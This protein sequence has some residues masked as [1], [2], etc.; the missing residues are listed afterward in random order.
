MGAIPMGRG[1]GRHV[2]LMAFLA[3][4]AFVLWSYLP[5]LMPLIDKSL[6]FCFADFS[7]YVGTGSAA[8]RAE[9]TFNTFDHGRQV[10]ETNRAF[11]IESISIPM[12]WIGASDSQTTSLLILLSIILGCIGLG[13]LIGMIDGARTGWTGAAIRLA[14]IPL[15]FLNL[16]SVERTIHIWIWMTYAILPLL[17]YLGLSYLDKKGRVEGLVAYSLLF[18]VYGMVPHSL[19]YAAIIHAFLAAFALAMLIRTK[20]LDAKKVALFMALPCAVFVLTNLPVLLLPA[21][22]SLSYP[23]TIDMGMLSML[24]RNGYLIRALTM[25]NNWWPQVD[26]GLTP[27]NALCRAS[28]L[29]II[30]ATVLFSALMM[31]KLDE[32]ARWLA[33]LSIA[34]ILCSLLIAQG[35]NDPIIRAASSSLQSYGLLWA[36]ALFREWARICVMIPVFMATVFALAASAA[37]GRTRAIAVLAMLSLVIMNIASSPA[38]EQLRRF[39]AVQVP[40]DYYNLSALPSSDKILMIWPSASTK[41]NGN[42]AYAWNEEKGRGNNLDWFHDGYGSGLEAVIAKEDAPKG[43]LD[44]LD[45]R[46]V[47]STREELGAQGFPAVYDWLGCERMQYFT[48]CEN[49]DSITRFRAYRG[50]LIA[51]GNPTDHYGLYFLNL[52]DI[53]VTSAKGPWSRYALIS[54]SDDRSDGGAA[55]PFYLLEAEKDFKAA[56]DEVSD[57]RIGRLASGGHILEAMN[58]T[59][60]SRTITV[61]RE[62]DYTFAFRGQGNFTISSGGN[63]TVFSARRMGYTHFQIHLRQGEQG[64][65]IQAKAGSFLDS[66]II[67]PQDGNRTL[68]RLIGPAPATITSYKRLSPT[69]WDARVDS[70]EPFLLSFADSYSPYWEARVYREG[71]LVETAKSTKLFDSMNG[72]WINT[73]GE[74]MEVKVVFAPQEGFE[75]GLAVSA[76]TIG[77]CVIFMLKGHLDHHGI[78]GKGAIG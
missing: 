50:A 48:I 71:A 73:T 26:Y 9:F 19:M 54:G 64:I 51:E 35:M 30:G 74:D 33:T 5:L 37:R 59:I 38:G 34:V 70:P 65:S 2:C 61:Q 4:S 44:A 78:K 1:L 3:A 18:S 60:L 72:F 24:S 32:R 36:M 49:N 20:A 25:E 63:G 8:V 57:I 27:G 17:L 69:R 55:L 39:A 28:S 12:G 29:A 11:L 77:A 66:L 58:D 21:V 67:F 23:Y 47:I 43:L 53:A 31:R 15:Y 46:Y 68:D 10:T 7:S 41:V 62:G 16:W 42:S 6:E 56:N 22:R 45:I 14:I 13:S 52:T 40:A 76:L 75:Y